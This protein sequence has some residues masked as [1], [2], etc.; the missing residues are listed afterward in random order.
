[1]IEQITKGIKISIE[2]EFEG[3]FYKDDCIHYAFS[4]E[5]VIE[6][7]SPEVAQLIA[8][9]WNIM[10][11]LNENEIVIGE[12]V[13]GEKPV[14]IPGERHTYTSGCVLKSPF[15]AMKGSYLMV[16]LSNSKQFKVTIPTFKLSASF[17]QN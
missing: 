2:T 3:T 7:Q 9:K 10:E 1:M 4:Y 11:A 16:N 13:V 8:R 5:V 14:L 6:N 12:G 17:A 15:G